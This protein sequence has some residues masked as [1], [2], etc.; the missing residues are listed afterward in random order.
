M[1]AYDREITIRNGDTCTFI[2]PQP[3]MHS[4]HVC[5]VRYTGKGV[6]STPYAGPTP[7]AADPSRH[8]RKPRNRP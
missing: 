3:A 7:T 2:T 8:W 5:T 6:T 4:L 1:S